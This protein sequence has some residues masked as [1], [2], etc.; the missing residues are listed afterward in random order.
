MSIELYVG[1]LLADSV[2]KTIRLRVTEHLVQSIATARLIG[3]KSF[4]YKALPDITNA[5]KYYHFL[6]ADN[7]RI[8]VKYLGK[9]D[10]PDTQRNWLIN[11]EE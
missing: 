9:P 8:K 1:E 2:D 5:P 6:F 3:R 7:Y 4:E 11:I 10:K